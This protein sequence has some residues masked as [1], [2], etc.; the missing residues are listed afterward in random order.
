VITTVSKWYA[1][2][3]LLNGSHVR[4]RDWGDNTARDF[5]AAE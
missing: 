5:G 3:L 2:V 4:R 1:D